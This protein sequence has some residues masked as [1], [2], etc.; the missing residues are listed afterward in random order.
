MHSIG[1]DIIEI[2]R[3]EKAVKRWGLR[4]LRRTYTE[5]ELRLSRQKPSSLAARFAAKEAVM[6]TLGTGVRGVGWREIEILADCRGKPLVELYGKAQN[7][8]EELGLGKLAVSLSDSRE[9]A[10]AFVVG[11]I[12]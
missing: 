3:I 12:G 8:A 4:F 1:V 7:R 5:T 11:E 6:K 2:C 10:V 9:Y